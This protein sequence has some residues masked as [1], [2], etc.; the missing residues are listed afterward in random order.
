M[1]GFYWSRR[2]FEAGL[3]T[4]LPIS[5][6]MSYF[7]GLYCAEGSS[8]SKGLVALSFNSNERDTLAEDARVLLNSLFGLEASVDLNEEKHVCVV[9]VGSKTLAKVLTKLCGKGAQNKKVPWD[10]IG[11][12]RSEFLRGLF[13]GDGCIDRLRKKVVLGM[14][15]YDC[16]FGAQ[17]LLWGLGVFPSVS[18]SESSD[19][20]PTWTIV[21]Q[22]ENYSLFMGL[23]FNEQVVNGERIFGNDAF[24]YRKLQAVEQLEDVV[25]V[26]NLETTGSH[27]Y[28]ANGLSV[29]NCQYCGER[30]TMRDLNYDHVVPRKQGGVTTWENIAT[31]CYPCNERK[32]GR[33]PEQA[34]MKLLR[35]PA[36]PHALPLHAVFIEAGRIPPVWE[37]YLDW[38]KAQPHGNGF[39]LV[40]SN[41]A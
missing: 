17:S 27:S 9:R 21:L 20:K 12:Y 1:V 30:F 4:S 26:Y 28:I 25:V 5:K 36:R 33:T 40:T 3:P 35:K 15:A 37:P 38:A 34:G 24:V 19:R 10:L 39:Y 8:T 7:L 41:A 31:C 18:H 11:P 29:H 16:I 13:A 22:G 14:T 23:A 2:G 6:E 32:A